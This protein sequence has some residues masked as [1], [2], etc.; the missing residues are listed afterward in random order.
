M[1]NIIY[2]CHDFF[3]PQIN[4]Q[5][6]CDI[7]IEFL[8]YYYLKNRIVI[9][10]NFANKIGNTLFYIHIIYLHPTNPFTETQIIF[11]KHNV[12]YQKIKIKKGYIDMGGIKICI[13]NNEKNVEINNKNEMNNNKCN[14]DYNSKRFKGFH[15]K[16]TTVFDEGN[17]IISDIKLEINNNISVEIVL[18]NVIANS[19]DDINNSDNKIEF[20]NSNNILKE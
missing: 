6:L 11:D 7:G 9:S 8:Y 13:Y 15:G 3:E 12:L 10:N 4:F 1:P 14:R 2:F 18:T 16:G 20:N 17:S 5:N 19:T